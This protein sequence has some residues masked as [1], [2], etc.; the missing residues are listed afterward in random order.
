MASEEKKKWKSMIRK[1]TA[2]VCRDIHGEY[3]LLLLRHP[4]AGIQ[5]PG[6]TIEQGEHEEDAAR[7]EA[8]EETG[9]DNLMLRAYAGYDD[10]YSEDNRG[11]IVETTQLLSRPDKTSFDWAK[12]R[13]GL[14]V[15]KLREYE[16]YIQVRYAE[17]N[18]FPEQ[19]YLTYVLIGWIP[20]NCYSNQCR[21]YFYHFDTTETR[22]TWK[23]KADNHEFE[24]F[25]APWSNLPE[26]VKPQDEWIET[27]KS[28]LGYEFKA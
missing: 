5:I 4:H 28:R 17:Y 8:R 22:N 20:R 12:L 19:H 15:E 25:W 26:I 13:A 10:T 6:G 16:Q 9:L 14:Q 21:R 27:V 1:A 23:R 24:L 3:E 7:R 18:S 2:F 11:Y